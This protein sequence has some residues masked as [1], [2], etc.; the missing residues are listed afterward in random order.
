MMLLILFFFINPIVTQIDSNEHTPSKAA[1]CLGI[2]IAI[3]LGILFFAWLHEKQ[4]QYG[5][6]CWAMPFLTLFFISLLTKNTFIPQL[7]MNKYKFGNFE[8]QQ[9]LVDADGC[10]ILKNLKLIPDNGQ[11]K[12]HAP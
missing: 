10:E 7:V 6:L 5:L 8:V 2:Y 9:L 11:K 1:L 12:P 3:F 4:Q